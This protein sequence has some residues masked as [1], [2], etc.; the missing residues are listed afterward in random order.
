ML[1]Q[2][3]VPKLKK[4]DLA[5]FYVTAL[6]AYACIPYA[7]KIGCPPTRTHDMG[8]CI[9]KTLVRDQSILPGLHAYTKLSNACA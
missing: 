2:S 3:L 7:G 4:W 9:R 5:A 6:H 1:D 8:F